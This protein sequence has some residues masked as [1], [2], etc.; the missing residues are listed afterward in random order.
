MAVGDPVRRNEVIRIS[1]LATTTDVV[2]S[3]TFENC[4]ITGPAVLVPLAGTQFIS[5]AFEAPDPESMLWEIAPTRRY[6]VGAIGLLNCVFRGCRFT[7]IGFGGPREALEQ[8]TAGVP[9]IVRE[10]ET[11]PSEGE[12]IG[13]QTEAPSQPR[14]AVDYP[15]DL[16]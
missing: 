8:F 6:T 10:P 4:V 3:M 15:E 14:A 7:R 13:R 2:A 5:S 11:A 9:A 12:A 16:R 1:D